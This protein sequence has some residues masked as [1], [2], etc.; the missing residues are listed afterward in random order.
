MMEAFSADPWQRHVY[1]A[2]PHAPWQGSAVQLHRT[3]LKG[4]SGD[5]PDRMRNLGTAG[6]IAG[7]EGE[8]VCGW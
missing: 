6:A 1:S 8:V 3:A 2:G 5:A 7:A 4:P